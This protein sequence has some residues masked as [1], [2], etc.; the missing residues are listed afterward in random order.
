MAYIEKP[1][2]RARTS[3]FNS[4]CDSNTN[5]NTF[6]E[7]DIQKY[8]LGVVQQMKFPDQYDDKIYVTG[9]TEIHFTTDVNDSSIERIKKIISEVLHEHNKELVERS[10]EDGDTSMSAEEQS[11][12]D[13]KFVITYIVN[14]PGGSVSSIMGFV[15]YLNMVKKKYSNV[16]FVSVVTGLVA[17]AGTIMCVAADKRKMTKNAFAMIH[18]LSTNPGYTNYTRIQT[19]AD[20]CTKLHVTGL[21]IYLDQIG[22][23]SKNEE[24]IKELETKLLRET[25][26]SAEEYKDLGFVDEIM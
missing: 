8:I 15:D 6:A 17:S 22:K 12:D 26:L 11:E 19:H 10:T 18:E 13:K 5:T 4:N 21:N 24:H 3:S 14:S 9:G 23:D 25:W 2:K 1:T 20:F 16:E 7:H